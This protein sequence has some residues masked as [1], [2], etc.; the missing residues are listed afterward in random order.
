VNVNSHGIQETKLNVINAWRN[1]A[2][3]VLEISEF[4]VTNILVYEGTLEKD[5]NTV[6]ELV[7]EKQAAAI[8]LL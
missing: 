4:C 8:L 2:K 6:V 5:V 7:S 3:I 1:S